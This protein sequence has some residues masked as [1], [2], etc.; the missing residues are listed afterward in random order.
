M[1]IWQIYET[2]FTDI[3]IALSVPKGVG[4]KEIGCCSAEVADKPSLVHACPFNELVFVK[5]CFF[6][7]WRFS[8]IGAK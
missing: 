4:P 3:E 7:A 8:A 2:Y 1:R 5:A 6:R